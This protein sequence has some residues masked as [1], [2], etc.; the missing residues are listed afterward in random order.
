MNHKPSKKFL[1][2]IVKLAGVDC[3]EISY[4]LNGERMVIFGK[5]FDPADGRMRD[6]IFRFEYSM[7]VPC[8][9]GGQDGAV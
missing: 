4:A 8:Q 3:M 6:Y 2:D 7:W 9:E 1:E 5:I